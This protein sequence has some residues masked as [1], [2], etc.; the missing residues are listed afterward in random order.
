MSMCAILPLMEIDD[1][2]AALR[3]LIRV[4]MEKS[5][6][7][8]TGLA[9]AAGVSPSTVT[10]FLNKPV[11]HLLTARTLAKLSEASEVSVP[12]VGTATSPLER[13]VLDTLR[14]TDDQ[15]REMMLRFSRSIR[16]TP[17]EAPPATPPKPEERPP[18]PRPRLG[19]SV[20]KNAECGNLK[21]VT[22][23]P[24]PA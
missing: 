5:G 9:R 3:N 8:A 16:A 7:D 23:R 10:R 18:P 11:K 12:F 22:F 24:V 4:M 20:A 21:V 13:E 17:S 1:Q 2:R 19:G 15:G 14:T 6:L